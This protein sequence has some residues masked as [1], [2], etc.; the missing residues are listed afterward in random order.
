M[1]DCFSASFTLMKKKTIG[2]KKVIFNV[3]MNSN[4]LYAQITQ[5]YVPTSKEVKAFFFLAFFKETVEFWQCAHYMQSSPAKF[6]AKLDSLN[7]LYIHM[8][9][10]L[11]YP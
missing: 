4:S 6:W 3:K 8:R 2:V 11:L 5:Q 7:F 9:I 10:L 1:Q